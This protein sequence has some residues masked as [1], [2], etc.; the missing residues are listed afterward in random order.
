M[1]T[2]GGPGGDLDL[3][4]FGASL[5]SFHDS[6]TPLEGS[7]LQSSAEGVMSSSVPTE[8]FL[9]G[10]ASTTF[11]SDPNIFLSASD[12]P[13]SSQEQEARHTLEKLRGGSNFLSF[14]SLQRMAEYKEG[15]TE[16][17]ISFIEQ[18]LDQLQQIHKRELA[19]MIDEQQAQVK[20]TRN[21]AREVR[22]LRERNELLNKQLVALHGENTN[23]R[24][25][26]AELEEK[27]T[28]EQTSPEV[29]AILEEIKEKLWGSSLRISPEKKKRIS[30]LKRLSQT[31]FKASNEKH[32]ALLM[33]L[34]QL[35]SSLSEPQWT[36]LGF[37]T[38]DPGSELGKTGILGLQNLV[39]FSERYNSLAKLG[40]RTSP[41]P[42]ALAGIS[43][44]ALLTS[45]LHLHGDKG[46]FTDLAPNGLFKTFIQLMDHPKAFEEL[47]CVCFMIYDHIIKSDP[48]ADAKELTKQ[49]LKEILL[50]DPHDLQE[51]MQIAKCI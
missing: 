18:Q 39:Y 36:M 34:W 26:I 3:E 22:R 45:L 21:Q 14:S 23:L 6:L 30:L 25:T 32:C 8:S 27:I 41:Y 43:I 5:Q 46:F 1:M 47:Y 7:S 13:L 24:E 10:D 4:S 17:I 42:W 15:A 40:G 35:H 38:E 16:R 48:N 44:T 9:T 20:Q 50:T 19:K 28:R 11:G 33:R 12:A 51:L 2:S 31:R 29:K 49:K 37:E